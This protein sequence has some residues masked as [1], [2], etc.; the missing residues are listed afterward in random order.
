MLN[1]SRSLS[2][3][4]LSISIY[5]GVVICGFAESAAAQDNLNRGDKIVTFQE[6]YNN[7]DDEAL[8]LLYARQR[9]A[10][11]DLLSAAGTL[12]RLLYTQPTWDSA[13]LYY[14]LVLHQLDDKQAALRELDILEGRPLSIDQKEQ[15]R[16]HRSKIMNSGSISSSKKLSGIVSIGFGYDDNVGNA[17]SDSLLISSD[18]ADESFTGY[19]ALNYSTPV[20][21]E[22]GVKFNA[23]VS[24][25]IRRQF[26]FT[27]SDY[28]S[29][30]GRAGFS[31]NP[32]GWEWSAALDVRQVNI[33]G[34]KYLT[35]YG[36]VLELG[37]SVSNTVSL[38][39]TG[40]YFDQDYYDLPFTFNETDR[41]G[42]RALI[43]PG[44]N[45]ESENGLGVIV[46][47]G[48]ET[49]D[50]RD[51]SFAY[52]GLRIQGQFINEFD[53]SVYL[54]GI[55]RYRDLNYNGTSPQRSDEQFEGRLAIGTQVNKVTGW[56]GAKPNS[57][58]NDLSVETGLNYTNRSSNIP[59][60]EYENLGAEA[61]L[62]ARF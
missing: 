21:A 36:P 56:L 1:K 22:D 9:A 50:A 32:E 44:I 46:Q 25:L 10:T 35:Q 3:I 45:Y 48:Y 6:V 33:D 5:S 18:E 37:K 52:D 4:A 8:N 41:S 23:T 42:S 53:N 20:G 58:L 29:F 15:L 16:L 2:H 19:A 38:I 14:A 27:Q 54:T 34:D 60:F 62:I 40:S 61:R 31:D 43:M 12:E 24:G 51:E 28:S 13:R 55:A 26:S 17:L 57:R 11:G 30:G 47:I 59:T 39:L 49:K 7:P